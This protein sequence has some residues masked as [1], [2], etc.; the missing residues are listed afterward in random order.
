MTAIAESLETAERAPPIATRP[1]W[2]RQ[3]HSFL[4]ALVV[5]NVASDCLAMRFAYVGT[6]ATMAAFGFFS[7]QAALL[8]LWMALGGLNFPARFTIAAA[9]TTA[10]SFSAAAAEFGSVVPIFLDLVVIAGVIVLATHALLLP[11][12]PLLGWRIDFDSAYHAT[13]HRRRMQLRLADCIGLVTASALPLA[14]V[15]LG[16]AALLPMAA[17]GAYAFLGG[18]PLALLVTATRRTANAW[19]LAAAC[20]GVLLTVEYFTIGDAFDEEPGVLVPFNVGLLTAVLLNLGVLRYFFG[21]HLLSVIPSE[22]SVT[23]S[24]PDLKR[25]N[26]DL[27][28]VVAVWTDLPETTRNEIMVMATGRPRPLDGCHAE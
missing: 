10:G 19:W 3:Q 24:P 9:A 23:A 5:L 18:L 2:W 28:R 25:L 17:A 20:W 21:L 27:A 1:V 12:R 11:L 7:A 26:D 14:L 8:G 16:D 13:P 22:V 15:R 4:A 6:G